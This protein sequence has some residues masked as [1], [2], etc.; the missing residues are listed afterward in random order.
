MKLEKA[1]KPEVYSYVKNNKQVKIW[2]REN[3]QKHEATEDK[4]TYWSYDE[5][6]LLLRDRADLKGYI[7]NN[8]N[9]LMQKAKEVETEEK[10]AKVQ[11]ELD[12][13]DKVYSS[14]RSWREYVVNNPNQFSTQAVARMQE[15]EDKAE[16]LRQK[17]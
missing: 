5:F 1:E 15:A 14:D 6:A 16:A 13:I 10:K 11:A 8:F 17:L 3:I 4:D 9:A 7:V 2:F 12:K